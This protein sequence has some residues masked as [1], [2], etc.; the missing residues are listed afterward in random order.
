MK[1]VDK[2]NYRLMLLVSVAALMWAMIRI[3]ETLAGGG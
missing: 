3:A 1:N 2:L